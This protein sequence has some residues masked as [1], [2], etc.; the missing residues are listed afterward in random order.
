MIWK[1]HLSLEQMNQLCKNTAIEHLGICF[2]AQGE[3]WLK[4]VMPI[5]EKTIQPMGFLHGGISA[6]LAETLGS[7]AGFCC[8]TEHQTVFGLE[9]NANHLRPVKQG[10]VVA[11]ATPLHLGKQT[12]VWQIE[13]KDQHNKLCCISRLTLAVVNNE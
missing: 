12:Q 13:I 5:N 6:A 9:I 3:N 8:I 7:M 10:E 1:K 11:T 4:A 2:I